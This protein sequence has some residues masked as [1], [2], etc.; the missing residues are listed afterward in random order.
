[1]LVR[2]VAEGGR[3]LPLKRVAELLDVPL[4][5]LYRYT[6]NGTIPVLRL[7][8]G[9]IRIRQ[10]ELSNLPLDDLRGRPAPQRLVYF[11][12]TTNNRVKIGVSANPQ[13]RLSALKTGA[14]TALYLIGTIPGD[15]DEER[16]LHRKFARYRVKGEWFDLAGELRI[17]LRDLFGPAVDG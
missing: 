5:R 4:K 7:P 12:A 1:M 8:G 14:T 16:Q 3:A 9:L 17:Y 15:H 10:S 2:E 11:I 13:K 6:R